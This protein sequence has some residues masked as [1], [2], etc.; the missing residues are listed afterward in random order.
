MANSNGKTPMG[1]GRDK[2]GAAGAEPLGDGQPAVS[3]KGPNDAVQR[4]GH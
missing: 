2:K 1:Y 4:E 3:Q